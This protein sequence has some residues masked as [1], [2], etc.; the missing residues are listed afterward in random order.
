MPMNRIFAFLLLFSTL[1]V[2]GA[3]SEEEIIPWQSVRIQS[4]AIP[5]VGVVT[6]EASTD[7]STFKQF[8]ITAFGRTHALEGAELKRLESFP[9]LSL[10]LTHEAGYARLGG[11]TLYLKLCRTYH[12]EAKKQKHQ[13]VTI[14]LQKDALPIVSEPKPR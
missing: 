12:D 13:A 9:L 2:R 3:A 10:T 14:S 7:G 11:H 5:T 6:V 1:L 8:K 4:P